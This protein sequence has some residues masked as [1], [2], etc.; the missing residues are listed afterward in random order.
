MTIDIPANWQQKLQKI[1]W[2]QVQEQV[3]DYGPVFRVVRD[4]WDKET[5][6]EVAQGNLFVSDDMMNEAIAKQ[7]PADGGVKGVTLK[8]HADGKLDINIDTKKVGV[9]ELQGEIKSFTHTPESS[10]LTYHVTSRN[11]KDHG[12]M[13]W[14]FSRVSLGMVARMMGNVHISD[15]MPVTIK[16]RDITVDYTKAIADSPLG[17]TEY[18]GQKLADMI[19]IEDATPKD[20]GIMFKTKLNV[21]DNVKNALKA[22]AKEKASEIQVQQDD[23]EGTSQAE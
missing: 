5:L 14:V 6:A 23:T 1:D 9:V 12:L 22:I 2:S 8:S 10:Q 19:E 16:H 18:Q 17:Q 20:G 15:D 21:S 13:S 4:T 3:K 11:I 7:I